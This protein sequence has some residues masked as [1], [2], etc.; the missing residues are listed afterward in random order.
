MQI[1]KITNT[2]IRRLL[3]K[4]IQEQDIKKHRYARLCGI[5]DCMIS[6]FLKGE[7]E[8]SKQNLMI[9]Y[10]DINKEKSNE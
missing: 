6:L 10:Q 9:I 3:K 1:S 8:L 2:N 5:S 7:R 4:Y